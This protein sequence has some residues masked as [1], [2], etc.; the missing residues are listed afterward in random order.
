MQSTEK[1][2]GQLEQMVLLAVL[3]LE[4]AYGVQIIVEL[5]RRTG[6]EIPRGS[7]YITLDRLAAKGYLESRRGEATPLRGGRA[8]RYF[9]LTPL[10]LRVLGESR[11][12]L[13]ALW[14]G[15]ESRLEEA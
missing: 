8:K 6:R 12:A 10:G 13:L 7:L 2:L 11:R 3:R 15:L 1:P 4:E 14:Q 9:Q 5:N